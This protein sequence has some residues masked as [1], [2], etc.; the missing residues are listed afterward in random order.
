MF[1]L[2]KR[3]SSGAFTIPHRCHRGESDTPFVVIV[4][5]SNTISVVQ[6]LF[7]FKMG[8]S[9]DQLF[10]P[11]LRS[12]DRKITGDQTCRIHCNFSAC[13]IYLLFTVDKRQIGT[14][15]NHEGSNTATTVSQVV[16]NKLGTR[17]C[18]DIYSHNVSF[19][20]QLTP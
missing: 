6:L 15:H 19:T 14:Q 3:S 17:E 4:Q 16:R 5:V 18:N 13:L 1:A 20:D 11:T 7:F 2:K 8:T 10:P 9:L 12:E